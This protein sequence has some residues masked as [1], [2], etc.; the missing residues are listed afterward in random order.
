MKAFSLSFALLLSAAAASAQ[1][2]PATLEETAAK[3]LSEINSDRIIASAAGQGITLS[4]IR[5]QV[6]PSAQQLRA[7]GQSDKTFFKELAKVEEETLNAM[8]EHQLVIAEFRAGTGKLPAIY[9]DGR[10]EEIIRRDFGGDRNRYVASLRAAGLTPISHRKFIEDEIIFDYMVSEVRRTALVVGP[11]QISE[12]FEKH[13]ADFVRNEQ[14]R[15]RQLTLTPGAAE[16][17][18]DARAR[19]TVWADALRHPEKIPATLARFKINTTKLNSA[20]TFG[21]IAER[22]STDGYATKGGDSGWRDVDAINEKV[23]GVIKKLPIGQASEAI[24]FDLPGGK[25]VWFIVVREGLH[26]KGYADLNDPDVIIDIE[27]RVRAENFKAAMNTWIAD[28]R[29]KHLVEIR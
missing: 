27:N 19:A 8:T 11:G 4:D 10:I 16:S 13:K 2:A 7:K 25:P 5:R 14:I 21:D 28:L 15:F 1:N 17:T 22:I 3:R 20:P 23:V 29:R 24:E 18:E 12:Y 9:T 26:P 6:E